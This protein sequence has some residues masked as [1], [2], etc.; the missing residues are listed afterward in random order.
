MQP[1]RQRAYSLP[2]KLEKKVEPQK[3]IDLAPGWFIP[4]IPSTPVFMPFVHKNIKINDIV[5]VYASSFGNRSL[6]FIGKVKRLGKSVIILSDLKTGEDRLFSKNP[7]CQF[8]FEKSF[9]SKL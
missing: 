2:I 6:I 5:N 4:A 7:Y 8:I 9:I 3:V 1:I